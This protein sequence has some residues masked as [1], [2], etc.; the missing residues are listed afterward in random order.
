METMC[1]CGEDVTRE[2]GDGEGR[3]CQV[4]FQWRIC[5]TG[6]EDNA[7]PS[8]GPLRSLDE[9]LIGIFYAIDWLDAMYGRYVDDYPA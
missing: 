1:L 8:L 7:Q 4:H 5:G 6:F 9:V 2:D 3:K